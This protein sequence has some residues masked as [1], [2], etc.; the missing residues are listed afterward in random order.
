[1][2]DT[3]GQVCGMGQ[4]GEMGRCVRCTGTIFPEICKTR[5]RASRCCCF[6]LQCISNE[7]ITGSAQVTNAQSWIAFATALNDSRVQNVFP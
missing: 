2:Q 3:L 6:G 1:M 5:R 7:S 4:D